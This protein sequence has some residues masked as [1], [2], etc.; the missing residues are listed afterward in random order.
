MGGPL[1]GSEGGGFVPEWVAFVTAHMLIR[2]PPH[3]RWGVRVREVSPH[4]YPHDEVV[5]F[6]H[7][8]LLHASSPCIFPLFPLFR[9]PILPLSLVNARE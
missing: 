4:C 2:T 6:S 9:F 7:F 3:I 5:D 8:S 1:A